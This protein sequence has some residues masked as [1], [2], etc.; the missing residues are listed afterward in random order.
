MSK[1]GKRK[2][3]FELTEKFSEEV[4]DKEILPE[5]LKN[6]SCVQEKKLE[7]ITIGYL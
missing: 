6:F 5:I 1:K 7:A 3:I 2:N 4:F